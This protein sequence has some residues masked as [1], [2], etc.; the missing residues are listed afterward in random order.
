EKFPAQPFVLD[1]IA[2]PGIKARQIDDLAANMRTRAAHPN[3]H[4][5]LSGMVTEADLKNWKPQ[6]FKPYLDVAYEA[7]GPDRLMFGSDWPV[8]LLA[9]SYHQVKQLLADYLA[10]KPPSDRD[11]IFGANAARFYSLK[12]NP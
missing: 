12:V 1:H 10:S 5:K 3:V 2:K 11:K 9:A 8:C 7:F 4:C 6:D